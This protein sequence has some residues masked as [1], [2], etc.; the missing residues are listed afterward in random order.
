MSSY[1]KPQLKIVG[2]N[3][4]CSHKDTINERLSHSTTAMILNSLLRLGSYFKS[5]SND[6]WLFVTLRG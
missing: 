5:T 1:F 4:D 2:T 3:R 6:D